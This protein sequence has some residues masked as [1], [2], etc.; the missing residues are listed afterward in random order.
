MRSPARDT[1]CAA[2]MRLTARGPISRPIGAQL[3]SSFDR[4][5]TRRT[6]RPHML[7]AGSNRRV[8]KGIATSACQ[9]FAV[10]RAVALQTPF[11]SMFWSLPSS[12]TSESVRAPSGLTSKVT[13]LR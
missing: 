1:Q 2:Y 11:H 10:L 7:A 8:E 3:L 5:T 12:V 13:L 6:L 9:P 4:R